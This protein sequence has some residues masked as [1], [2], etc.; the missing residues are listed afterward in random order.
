[1]DF[2]ENKR[3]AVK[4]N[5]LMFKSYAAFIRLPNKALILKENEYLECIICIFHSNILKT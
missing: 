5:H 2:K 3:R 1:M 4:A